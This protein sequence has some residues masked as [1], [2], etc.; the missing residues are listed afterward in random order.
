[1]IERKSKKRNNQQ[2]I[3]PIH[4]ILL[5]LVS[6]SCLPHRGKNGNNDER[7]TSSRNKYKPIPLEEEKEK[8]GSV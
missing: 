5:I 8:E 3:K 7:K 2:N 1:M 6:P 4:L